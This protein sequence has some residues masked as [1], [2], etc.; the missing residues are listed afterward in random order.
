MTET[1]VVRQLEAPALPSLRPADHA[2]VAAIERAL[3]EARRTGD[4]QAPFAIIAGALA[5]FGVVI[6]LRSRPSALL[7]ERGR[8]DWLRRLRSGGRSESALRAYRTAIDD[9]LSWAARS[10]R[11]EELFEERAI[12]D[13]LDDYRQRLSPAAATY[14][15]RFLILRRFMRWLSSREGVPDPFVDLEAP[16]K[17]RHEGEWLTPAEFRRMLEA[18]G[19][20]LRRHNGIV[21]RDRLV[22]LAL[23]TTGLRRSEL[24]NLDWRDLAL[25]DLQPSLLVRHGKGDKPRRQPLA[26]QLADELRQLQRQMLPPGADPVFRG[27]AGGRL[28][29]KV[30]AAIIKRAAE[31]GGLEKR[32]T[33]HTLRHTAAT[34][35]RQETGDT[36]LVAEYLGHADLSTVSRYTHVA[37][38]ELLHEATAALGRLASTDATEV[39]EQRAA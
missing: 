38:R 1:R 34:W 37:E 16:R 33:A 17:P 10:G 21:E 32:V 20:P 6:P 30:L 36:R 22:L 2:A 11:G 25:D 13:H 23:V 26:P 28:Q 9:L 14:H 31:R 39:H 19:K 29:P 24:I 35:L 7:V 18:A 12:V 3:L 5:E 27:L 15:R 8:D 4:D